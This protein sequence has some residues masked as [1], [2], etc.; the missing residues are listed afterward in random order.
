MPQPLDL[1]A[2]AANQAIR[3]TVYRYCRAMDRIDRELGLSIWTPD[4]TLDYG[5]IFRGRADDFIERVCIEHAAME[6]RS[7][8]IT[9]VIVDLG[10]DGRSAFS[11]SYVTASLRDSRD[12]ARKDRTIRGRYLDRWVRIDDRWLIA[13][14]QFAHDFTSVVAAE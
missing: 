5:P 8:Q 1:E 4:A 6:A 12:G 3:D 10:P 13:E 11:E 7:H 14:R 2:L 9:N